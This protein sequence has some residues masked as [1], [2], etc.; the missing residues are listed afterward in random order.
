VTLDDP[1]ARLLIL[2]VMVQRMIKS[3]ETQHPI[4]VNKPLLETEKLI[5]E[6]DNTADPSNAR[7]VDALSD[8]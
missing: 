1:A 5:V 3:H 4:I 7:E 6:K 8:T 2:M